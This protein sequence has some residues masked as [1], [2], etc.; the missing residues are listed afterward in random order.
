MAETRK[1]QFHEQLDRDR[2]MKKA[3]IEGNMEEAHRQQQRGFAEERPRHGGP[4]PRS[5]RPQ[6]QQQPFRRRGTPPNRP[7]TQR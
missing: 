3:I 2:R 6:Q 7:R 4:I 5:G 1:L